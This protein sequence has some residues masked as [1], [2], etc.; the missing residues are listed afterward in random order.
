MF[1]SINDH[2]FSMTKAE[3]KVADYV[4]QHRIEVQYMS[5]SELA[6]EC[7]VAD[8]TISRF[9]R[10]LGL[11]GYN[12][13]KLSLA[14]A[15]ATPRSDA[16]PADY[17]EGDVA[18]DDNF[19][20]MCQKLFSANVTAL[21]QTM[22]KLDEAHMQRAADMLYNADKV[23]C[24][25]QGGSLTIAQEACSLFSTVS[26]HFFIIQDSHLQAAAVSLLTKRDVVL[27]FSYSGA[28]KDMM[29]IMRLCKTQGTRVILIS[30]FARSPGVA[31]ADCVL[32]CGTNE[33]PLQH[34]SVPARV[35]QLFVVDVLFNELMRRDPGT[36]EHN[37][38]RIATALT[39]KHL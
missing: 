23:Y 10:D 15:A 37:R 5:I 31:Y 24:L 28:T 33:S 6:A 25:G 36:A 8:A 38:E 14:T 21:T 34:G 30:R 9:C 29:D 2:Y 7:G 12:D 3:K 35:A 13:F 4:M 27:Y 17:A 22:Q 20:N 11:K 32:L 18:A 26:S 1:T 19:S 39:D 16:I